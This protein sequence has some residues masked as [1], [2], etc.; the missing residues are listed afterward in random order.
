LWS[1][2]DGK[3]GKVGRHKKYRNWAEGKRGRRTYTHAKRH[4][5]EV[6]LKHIGGVSF[7]L[8]HPG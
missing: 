3:T 6:R 2:N 4:L 8:G 1:Q 5:G 7:D